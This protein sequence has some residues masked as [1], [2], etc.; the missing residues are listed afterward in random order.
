M[1]RVP[2]TV[3]IL[4]KIAAHNYTVA[5]NLKCSCVLRDQ[6][7]RFILTVVGDI[8]SLQFTAVECSRL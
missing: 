3:E 8:C 6:C 2:N 4:R 5:K 7:S 1:A